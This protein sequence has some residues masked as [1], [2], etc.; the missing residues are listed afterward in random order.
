[1]MFVCMLCACIYVRV[2]M[3]RVFLCVAF[4]DA[5]DAVDAD[6]TP[7]DPCPHHVRL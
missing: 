2:Y 6:A 4:E 3:M 7:H 1:M 5:D